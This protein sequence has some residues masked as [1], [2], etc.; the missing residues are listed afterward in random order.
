MNNQLYIYDCLTGKLRVANSSMM[1]IGSGVRNTF[2]VQMNRENG[3]S[4]VKRDDMCRFFPH[5]NIESYSLNGVRL[6][7]DCVI[8]PNNMYLMVLAGACLICWYGD[9]AQRPNF[10]AYDSHIWYVYDKDKDAW[11][12]PFNLTDLKRKIKSLPEQALATFQ[13]LE[14]C[15]FYLRDI[16]EVVDFVSNSGARPGES[17]KDDDARALPAVCRCPS[18]WEK[19]PRNAVL[20]I[21]T[22]PDLMHDDILGDGEMQRFIPS[23]FTENGLPLDAKG[24][25]CNEFACPYCH[26]K[27]PPFFTSSTQHIFSL[28]GVPAAGKSYYLA[29]LIHELEHEIPREFG[30]PFRDADPAANA[31]LNDMRMRLF[32][33]LSEQETYI[34]KTRLQSNVYHKV[35]RHNHFY[36]MPRPFTYRLNKGTDVYSVVF[37]D[38][39]GE[40]FE[41]GAPL[42][43]GPSVEH[44]DVASAIFF[45]FDPTANP[46]FRS[47]LKDHKDP[48]IH[49]NRRLAGRQSMLLTEAEMRLRS[50]LNLP[51]GQKLDVPLA[52]IIGKSDTWGHLLGP[53]PLLPVT[54][55]GMFMPEHVNVN[56]AR[57]RQ[58]LFNITP[59]ICT[60]IETISENVRYFMASALGESPIEFTNSDGQIVIGPQSGSVHPFRVTDPILWA[61]SCVEPSLLPSSQ[62]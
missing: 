30:I 56:S 38:N 7:G 57:L 33:G 44:L 4:F 49:L 8:K 16:V 18:C 19:F 45:L 55:S 1:P 10:S 62:K 13:G 48:Q 3:G 54:R 29:S 43:Q 12:G 28:I 6:K 22:H 47:L 27:L 58:F 14:N 51:Q 61:L 32:S 2:R 41:P 46:E 5:G 53:E 40:N 21:A 24:S 26:C 23:S 50:R 37:Y 11:H 31:P 15:A 9:S 52:V 34:G 39:A 20:A 25:P 35:W 59:H 36:S 60:N 17:P 42:E